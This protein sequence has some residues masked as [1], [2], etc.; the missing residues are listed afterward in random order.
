MKATSLNL[1]FKV[2]NVSMME[3]ELT[4]K[5]G[6]LLYNALQCYRN[7]LNRQYDSILEN[8]CIDLAKPSYDMLQELLELNDKL[9]DLDI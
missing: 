2:G 9:K 6:R 1:Q 5:E 4:T 7:A 3:V 8:K